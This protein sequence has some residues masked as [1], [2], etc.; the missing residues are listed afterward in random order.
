M[1]SRCLIITSCILVT[2]QIFL[3]SFFGEG[4]GGTSIKNLLCI[5]PLF[6]L[7]WRTICKHNCH[8][9]ST[10]RVPSW[11]VEVLLQNHH[12]THCSRWTLQKP[13]EVP[14]GRLLRFISPFHFPLFLNSVG[15]CCDFLNVFLC[16]P[17]LCF[18]VPES[19]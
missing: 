4:G 18:T 14:F 13:Q 11:M 3:F 2:E 12:Q 16:I 10:I 9:K 8:L 15:N 19:Q 1:E 6:T 5:S 17:A 7:R